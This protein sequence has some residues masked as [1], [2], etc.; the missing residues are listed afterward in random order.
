MKW[1][2][3][4]F[5]LVFASSAQAG[6]CRD[7]KA[8][9]QAW[10]ET[11]STYGSTPVRRI[12]G[13]VMNE[14]APSGCWRVIHWYYGA[15]E[16]YRLL[17]GGQDPVVFMEAL[18]NARD[19]G[20]GRAQAQ[21]LLTNR[22]ANAKAGERFL[23]DRIV[24]MANAFRAQGTFS[25][26][27]DPIRKLRFHHF[28]G[29]SERDFGKTFI[30]V[31]TAPFGAGDGGRRGPPRNTGAMAAA[32]FYA[33][34][35]NGTL[36]KARAWHGFTSWQPFANA[37]DAKHTL[38][39][40]LSAYLSTWQHVRRKANGASTPSGAEREPSPKL[41]LKGECARAF[42]QFKQKAAKFKALALSP[43]GDWCGWAYG[44][45]S[46][47]EIDAKAVGFCGRPECKV[48]MR[49]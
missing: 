29:P 37:E 49:E 10:R 21:M 7:W 2:L 39:R 25:R 17:A 48:A 1:L 46:Q 33:V 34:L 4:F 12:P 28:S 19:A 38:S 6:S 31:A 44:R 8:P 9:N 41:S 36:Y 15:G 3:S 13:T 27:Y 43:D 35:P 47:A 40:L 26:S 18:N 20:T 22:S 16:A 5:F 14:F 42:R 24:E 30:V 23:K 32:Y 11:A 45:T